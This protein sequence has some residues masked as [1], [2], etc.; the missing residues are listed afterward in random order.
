MLGCIQEMP[1]GTILQIRV[2]MVD[3]RLIYQLDKLNETMKEI[4]KELKA[5]NE[6]RPPKKKL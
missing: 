3:E 5:I 6:H 2:T 1:R 4:V